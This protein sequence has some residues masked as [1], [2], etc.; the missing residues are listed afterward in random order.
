MAAASFVRSALPA[1]DCSAGANAGSGTA[2]GTCACHSG[3]TT[4]G[5]R[6]GSDGSLRP[7]EAAVR[8]GP[9]TEKCRKYGRA[10]RLAAFAVG[11]RLVAA[12]AREVLL[13]AL[14]LAGVAQ[15]GRAADL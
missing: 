2:G 1:R 13:S 3:R 14:C 8:D 5:A 15:S 9:S 10:R 12:L 11:V 4:E 7:S 6:S